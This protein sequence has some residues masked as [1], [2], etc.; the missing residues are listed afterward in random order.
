MP[1]WCEGNIRLRGTGHAILE[2]MKNEI[3]VVG[4][5][6][7]P[8]VSAEDDVEIEDDGCEITVKCPEKSP[9][10][11]LRSFYINNTRRNFI[12]GKKIYFYIG[13]DE[14]ERK[15][16]RTVCIDGFKAAWGIG[17]APYVEKARK[18]G[19]DIKIVGIVK[20]AVD[21]W[22]R[23]RHRLEKNPCNLEAEGMMKDCEAFFRSEYFTNMTG[24]DG[25]EFLAKL[26]KQE[27][28]GV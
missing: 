18:Y 6:A 20:K 14:D 11:F 16:K 21:D 5:G 26:K 19:L 3:R 17:S 27:E 15:E 4:R 25:R 2:F 7:N 10:L 28:M 9:V 8:L 24:L 22:K 23:A 12:D 13:D 1:N